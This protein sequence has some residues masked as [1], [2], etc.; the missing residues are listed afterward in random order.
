MNRITFTTEGRTFSAEVPAEDLNVAQVFAQLVTPVLLA[1]GFREGSIEKYLNVPDE[2]ILDQ[3][4][5]S[6]D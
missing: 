4:D 1:A 2:A 5:A 6:D 3:Y